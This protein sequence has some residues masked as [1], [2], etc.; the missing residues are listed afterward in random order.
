MAVA[1]SS[2][3]ERGFG[4]VV[5]YSGRQ[6]AAQETRL[7]NRVRTLLGEPAHKGREWTAWRV[8]QP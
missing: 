7:A 2:L 3:Q 5:L 6:R 1:V 4:W 8:P